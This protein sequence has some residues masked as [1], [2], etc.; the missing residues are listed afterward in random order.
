VLVLMDFLTVKL[1]ILDWIVGAVSVLIV[2][3]QT[4]RLKLSK[5]LPRRM[6][7]GA[8]ELALSITPGRQHP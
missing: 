2:V 6:T 8:Q 1:K 3:N 5:C 4:T 7:R